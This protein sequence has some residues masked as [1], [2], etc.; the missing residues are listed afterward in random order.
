MVFVH[1]ML[2]EALLTVANKK[3]KK[4]SAVHWWI[5]GLKVMWYVR[6][7]KFLFSLE[8][9]ESSDICYNRVMKPEEM[10]SEVS[11]RRTNGAW[12]HSYKLSK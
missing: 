2:I 12:F 7:K 10:L 6:T 9:Q 11:Q 5:G 3:K 4:K 8:K 1:Q